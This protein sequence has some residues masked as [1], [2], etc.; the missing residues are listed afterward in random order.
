MTQA[1]SQIQ[2]QPDAAPRSAIYDAVLGAINPADDE[3][4]SVALAIDAALQAALDHMTQ[5]K[6]V[7][8]AIEAEFASGALLHDAI[9]DAASDAVY[10]EDLQNK[11]ASLLDVAMDVLSHV[12]DE[13]VAGICPS[14][15]NGRVSMTT[16][17][18]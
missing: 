13:A 2:K 7:G 18:N 11:M 4:L 12:S 10:S 14:C 1:E 6:A 9:V 16:E 15:A 17:V 3:F 8:V 5:K